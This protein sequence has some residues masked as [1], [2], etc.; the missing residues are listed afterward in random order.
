MNPFDRD[1]F[2]DPEILRGLMNL[3]VRFRRCG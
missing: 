3:P 1:C 2:A